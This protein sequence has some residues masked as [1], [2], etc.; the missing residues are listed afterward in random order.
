MACRLQ[1]LAARDH[2]ASL[3]MATAVPIGRPYRVNLHAH[4]NKVEGEFRTVLRHVAA[5]PRVPLMDC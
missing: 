2:P 3:A 4:S 1:L 5:L